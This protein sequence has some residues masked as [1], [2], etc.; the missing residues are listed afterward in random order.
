M[1]TKIKNVQTSPVKLGKRGFYKIVLLLIIILCTPLIIQFTN[2]N[3]ETEKSDSIIN[4][5]GISGQE[6]FT[7]QWLNNT[8]FEDPIQPAWFPLFGSLGDN[9]DVNATTSTG[10]VNY[11]VK[12]ESNTFDNVSSI[13]KPADGWLPFN[14]SYFITPDYYGID[15]LTGVMASHTYDESVDQSRNRPSIHWRRNITMPVNMSEYII[16]SASINATVNGSADT[17]VETPS[18]DLTTGGAGW[19]ATYYDYARF[20]VKISNLDYEDL[21]EVAYYQTVNLGQGDQIPGG[22]GTINYLTDTIMSVIEESTL[23]FYLTR[24]LENDDFHFGITLGIDVYTEDNYDVY[25]LDIFHSLRIKSFNLSFSYEKRMNELTSVSWNQNADKISDLSNDTVIVNEARLNFMYKIDQDWPTSSP[26]S[27]FRILINNNQHPETIKLNT[28]NSTFQ[29][30]KLGGFDVTSLITDDVNLSIQLFLADSF[31]LN[32]TITTSIDDVTLNITYTIIFPDKGADL[33]LFINNNNITSDP[34]FE[35]TVGQ[36]LNITIKYMNQTGDHITNATVLLSGNFTGTLNESVSLEQYTIIL[37]TDISNVGANFLTIT[38]KAENYQLLKITPTITIN[39]IT[40]NDLQVILNDIN[41]TLDPNIALIVNEELNITIQYQDETGTHIPN[42]TVRLISEGV[43]KTLNES[44]LLEHY[45]TIVN[46]SDRFKIGGNLLTIEAKTS[47]FQTK[48][49]LINLY[50]RKINV[51]VETVSGS[52][53]IISNSGQDIL[54]QIRLN[55]TD[56]GGFMKNALVT[57]ISDIGRNG[58]IEDLDNNGI[59]ETN[60]TGLPEGAFSFTIQAIINDNYNIQEFELTIVV[61]Q[62]T[63]DST[64]FRIL[65]ILSIILVSALG[66]YL[67]AYYK[68]LKYPRPVRKIRKYRKTLTRKNSPN[69][70]ILD[71]EKSFSIVFSHEESGNLKLQKQKPSETPKQEIKSP[72]QEKPKLESEELLKESLEMKKGLD[73]IVDESRKTKKS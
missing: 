73:K 7:K 47:T 66:S 26:N 49:A 41:K 33:H 43:T 11:E 2:K 29:I 52:N 22:S 70:V 14:N 13:P 62:E 72:K 56:F 36:Q 19:S 30:A 24:A 20:Y 32:R 50:I 21:Y 28:A 1:K 57:Y 38:A 42:A 63:E 68:Y 18:D 16:T 6:S 17:N 60:I 25:D 65:F 15:S 69:I 4:N 31:G 35:L 54:L 27:E 5:I 3:Y 44:L 12:G 51:E 40:T 9:S 37:D 61:I 64:L 8:S 58:I 48:Y 23:I 55:N 67:I 59:Y 46:T 39:K 53:T 71:R 34:N 45:S 10:Q